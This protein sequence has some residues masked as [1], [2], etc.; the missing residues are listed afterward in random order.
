MFPVY[1]L[2]RVR[3]KLMRLRMRVLLLGIHL[4][5]KGKIELEEVFADLE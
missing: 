3:Y 2:E 4:K 5:E 1:W